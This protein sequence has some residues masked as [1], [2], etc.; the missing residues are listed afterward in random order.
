MDLLNVSKPGEG[1]PDPDQLNARL[2][3]H[4]LASKHE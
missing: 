4:V 2:R 3:C 1:E